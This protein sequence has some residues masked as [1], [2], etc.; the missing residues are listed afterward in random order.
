ML[1]LDTNALLWLSG[2]SE[3]LG[4]IARASIDKAIAKGS[5]AFS[6]ISV[7]ETATLVRKGRYAIGLPIERWR[8]DLIEAGLREAPLDG[9]IAA[10]AGTYADLHD[11]P[12]DRF[13]AATATHLAAKLVTS[14]RRLLAWAGNVG[15]DARA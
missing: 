7:W 14:D 13:I 6:A 5:A 10:L 15:I 8:G 12:A 9:I 1:L 3:A 2:G 11:D 4:P